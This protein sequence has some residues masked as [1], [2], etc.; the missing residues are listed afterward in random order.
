V[1]LRLLGACTMVATEPRE[2]DQRLSIIIKIVA[3][4]SSCDLNNLSES[5][6]NFDY[7]VAG[8]DALIERNAGE[9][10]A[11]LALHFRDNDDVSVRLLTL[12]QAV[13]EKSKKSCPAKGST[14]TLHHLLAF[15]QQTNDSKQQHLRRDTS[16]SDDNSG[17][18]A[19]RDA[20]RARDQARF[21]SQN[22]ICSTVSRICARCDPPVPYKVLAGF[23][24]LLRAELLRLH[25][26]AVAGGESAWSAPNDIYE[27]LT[28]IF[29]SRIRLNCK[30]G[31]FNV[32]A[33]SFTT[34]SN[35]PLRDTLKDH[36]NLDKEDMMCLADI[37]SF[38]SSN[39]FGMLFHTFQHIQFGQ[40]PEHALILLY[41]CAF[42]LENDTL[43]CVFTPERR[44]AVLKMRNS[45]GWRSQEDWS[46]LVPLAG[47]LAR[48]AERFPTFAQQLTVVGIG[49]D[50]CYGVAFICNV[51][52]DEVERSKDNHRLYPSGAIEKV[53]FQRNLTSL[54]ECLLGLSAFTSHEAVACGAA[55]TA[56]HAVGAVSSADGSSINE[57]SAADT[58]TVD[59][60][61]VAH[62]LVAG[63][64]VQC[65]VAL[66][67]NAALWA[68]SGA[69]ASLD[70]EPGAVAVARTLR[71]LRI[72]IAA[73]VAPRADAASHKNNSD[74][75]RLS[76]VLG[77]FVAARG[78]ETL[79]LLRYANCTQDATSP[80][81]AELNLLQ[82]L[83]GS[84]NVSSESTLSLPATVAVTDEHVR[85]TLADVHAFAQ[86]FNGNWHSAFDNYLT[87]IAKDSGLPPRLELISPTA[88]PADVAHRL[89]ATKLQQRNAPSPPSPLALFHLQAKS[90][91]RI[92]VF[93]RNRVGENRL[94][95]HSMV[96][97][98]TIYDMHTQKPDRYTMAIR[99][100]DA[101]FPSHAAHFRAAA[102]SHTIGKS[103]HKC[104]V[105][106]GKSSATLPFVSIFHSNPL[107]PCVETPFALPKTDVL[108]GEATEF[109]GAVTDGSTPC[110]AESPALYPVGTVLMY[111]RGVT[112]LLGADRSRSCD[113][114]WFVVFKPCPVSLL[115][116]AVPVGRVTSFALGTKLV[117]Y[118]RGANIFNDIVLRHFEG[119]CQAQRCS[120][121]DF[122]T[123]SEVSNSSP[124][125]FSD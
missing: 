50:V 35:T 82:M 30:S 89:K 3:S 24:P 93:V 95:M 111:P 40:R 34:E 16:S 90:R 19:A 80:A 77:C 54:L 65:C 33:F 120:H 41:L 29:K 55:A 116:G 6:F 12:T 101:R 46:L 78:P 63:N 21:R 114:P 56:A 28:A 117:K 115:C 88:K 13:V 98:V 2:G 109:T 71:I 103:F 105:P 9:L 42:T 1:L 87:F 62:S 45:A 66:L 67:R 97:K 73:C 60:S 43:E 118:D 75:S 85:Q 23:V 113:T 121:C 79:A 124:F 76:A 61:R 106:A 102:N 32:K 94:K 11:A 7:A 107:Y 39:E 110:S 25:A 18:T 37:A 72:L 64:A 26:A 36:D 81:R 108:Y 10:F 4:I 14:S 119:L 69:D 99:L 22:I 31:S 15:M 52:Y 59:V 57:A 112:P 47:L 68:P 58:F 100:D 49:S 48:L 104:F 92:M 27:A 125:F 122:G 5:H 84:A 51:A 20:A 96:F 83:L 70:P 123:R 53:I 17:D 91:E 44:H 8:I 38:S 74:M 86:A